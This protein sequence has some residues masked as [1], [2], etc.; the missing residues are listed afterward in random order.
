[1][2][3][4]VCIVTFIHV[5]TVPFRVVERVDLHAAIMFLRLVNAT[6][7]I[8]VRYAKFLNQITCDIC[9]NF[10]LKLKYNVMTHATCNN[11]VRCSCDIKKQRPM[12]DT[13]NFVARCLS[14]INR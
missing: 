11:L 9:I 4:A 8:K 6:F 13:F 7:L 14:Q 10:A 12:F 1:M 2:G 5:C 3:G